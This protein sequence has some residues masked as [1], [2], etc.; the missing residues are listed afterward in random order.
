MNAYQEIGGVPL[1][2]FKLC[3]RWI[4][5]VSPTRRSLYL[6]DRDFLYKSR[7]NIILP[8]KPRSS[9]WSVSFRRLY[10]KSAR[11]S[12]YLLLINKAVLVITIAICRLQ[13]QYRLHST[14]S[15]GNPLKTPCC[16]WKSGCP[17][18]S[19]LLYMVV[20]KSLTGYP[21]PGRNFIPGP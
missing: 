2:I 20:C 9:K 10:H 17:A 12:S 8:S 1:L 7:L 13:F 21:I 15:T 18:H 11:H 14:V 5:V 4:S 6:R 19:V 3:A 16:Y